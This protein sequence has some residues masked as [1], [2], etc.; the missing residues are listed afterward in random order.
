[1][2][3]K[4]SNITSEFDDDPFIVLTETKICMLPYTCLGSV[5]ATPDKS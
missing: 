5:F 1:M 4:F 2:K 3:Q